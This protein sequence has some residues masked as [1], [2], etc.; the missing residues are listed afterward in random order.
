[1]KQ[2]VALAE[3][4][5]QASYTLGICSEE[6]KNFALEKMAQALLAQAPQILEANRKD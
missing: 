4:A 3:A 1:M 6:K 5:K 2:V